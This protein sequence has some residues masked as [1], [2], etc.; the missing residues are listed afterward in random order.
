MRTTII[1]TMSRVELLQGTSTQR[2]TATAAVVADPQQGGVLVAP[3][4]Q[5]YRQFG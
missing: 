1:T 5:S 4:C 3:G 2:T